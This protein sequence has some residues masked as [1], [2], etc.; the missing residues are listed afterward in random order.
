MLVEI[1]IVVLYI[2]MGL[3]IHKIKHIIK[4]MEQFDQLLGESIHTQEQQ[5]KQQKTKQSKKKLADPLSRQCGVDNVNKLIFDL[6]SNPLIREGA[7]SVDNNEDVSTKAEEFGAT[8]YEKFGKY[9]GH[10][11]IFCT[12]FQ[13]LNWQRFSEVAEE[14]RLEKLQ[15]QQQ[16]PVGHNLQQQVNSEHIP[17]MSELNEENENSSQSGKK[18]I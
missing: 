2:I 1:L 12:V 6:Y 18:A 4:I 14:R 13:H 8:I 17:N 9:L 10:V 7:Q 16:D 15:Q 11:A 3:F 5:E